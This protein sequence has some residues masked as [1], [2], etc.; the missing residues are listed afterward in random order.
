[1][2]SASALLCIVLACHAQSGVS[3]R[4]VSIDLNLYFPIE[5]GKIVKFIGSKLNQKG[6]VVERYEIRKSI[7][8]V[9][10]DKDGSI[11]SFSRVGTPKSY[12][13]D[14][15]EEYLITRD[16]II[17]YSGDGCPLLKRELAAGEEWES[18][19]GG[20]TATK[21]QV[22]SIGVEEMLADKKV[23]NCVVIRVFEPDGQRY[24]VMTFAP[25]LGLIKNKIFVGNAHYKAGKAD[26]VE[27]L[28]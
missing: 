20:K 9:R 15:P 26:Y 16:K 10:E 6:D 3:V 18:P 17:D 1:M 25:S 12:S 7:G 2:A 24:Q 19:A 22:V 23:N 8:E 27:V 11:V 4:K 28:K 21:V 5:K 13:N 14:G